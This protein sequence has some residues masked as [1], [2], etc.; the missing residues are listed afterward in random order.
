[1]EGALLTRFTLEEAAKWHR[2]AGTGENQWASGPN[3]PDTET[4]DGPISELIGPSEFGGGG[5]AF[6]QHI[7]NPSVAKSATVG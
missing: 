5:S 3:V 6:R 7:E 1:M 2:K 4:A